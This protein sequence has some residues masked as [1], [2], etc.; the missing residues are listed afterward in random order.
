[1]ASYQGFCGSSLDL[2]QRF[3]GASLGLSAGFGAVA[4]L[5]CLA[6]A[7]AGFFRAAAA[8]SAAAAAMTHRASTTLRIFAVA[9]R[10]HL[11]PHQDRGCE[12]IESS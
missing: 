1:M 8:G 2:P 7:A 6:G 4:G 11:V 12:L 5:V 9:H 10:Y 3:F